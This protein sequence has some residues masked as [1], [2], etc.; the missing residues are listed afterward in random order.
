MP[1]PKLLP[2]ILAALLASGCV[3]VKMDPV[4]IDAT[5]TV[6]VERELEDFFNEIDEASETTDVRD[7]QPR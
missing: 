3:H 6:K 4:K 2:P 1:N 5:V 7:E